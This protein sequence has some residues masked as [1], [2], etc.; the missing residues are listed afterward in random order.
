MHPCLVGLLCTINTAWLQLQQ[1]TN[2]I[3]QTTAHHMLDMTLWILDDTR[4]SCPPVTWHLT[5]VANAAVCLPCI[6]TQQTALLTLKA[7]APLATS[8]SLQPSACSAP[9]LQRARGRHAVVQEK[10]FNFPPGC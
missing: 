5:P 4:P 3:E 6:T 1:H 9:R 8:T 7:R 10:P 2:H